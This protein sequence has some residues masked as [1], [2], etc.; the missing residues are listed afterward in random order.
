MSADST[1]ALEDLTMMST[2]SANL[3]KDVDQCIDD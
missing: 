2:V 1:S 3:L